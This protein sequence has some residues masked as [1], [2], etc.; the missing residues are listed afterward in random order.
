MAE[1]QKAMAAG[2][3]YRR[4]GSKGLSLN[5]QYIAIMSREIERANR[6]LVKAEETI[7]YIQ[8]QLNVCTG[9]AIE[10]LQAIL[11]RSRP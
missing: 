6:K 2:R 3:Q 11:D 8:A 4:W 7:K 10:Q 5:E 1:L 9:D